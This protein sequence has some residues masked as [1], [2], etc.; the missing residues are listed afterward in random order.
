MGRL[1]KVTVRI[2]NRLSSGGSYIADRLM[3][4]G[5]T[6]L[7]TR[8]S[9]SN[10]NSHHRLFIFFLPLCNNPKMLDRALEEGDEVAEK[11]ARRAILRQAARERVHVREKAARVLAEQRKLEQKNGPRCTPCVNAPSIWSFIYPSSQAQ[12]TMIRRT[13]MIGS[14]VDVLSAH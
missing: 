7:C 6:V 3:V 5:P 1:Q 8:E 12:P 10:K 13:Y 2:P 11:K 4:P 9:L 14:L